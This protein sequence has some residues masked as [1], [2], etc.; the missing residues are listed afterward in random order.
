MRLIVNV[1]PLGEYFYGRAEF[2]T[3]GCI[4]DIWIDIDVYHI[5]REQIEKFIPRARLIAK[6]IWEAYYKS[7]KSNMEIK[8]E[9]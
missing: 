2:N 7:M 6:N 1:Y 3:F 4:N 8:D 9:I 5:E